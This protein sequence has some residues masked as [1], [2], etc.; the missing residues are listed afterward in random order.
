MN[1]QLVFGETNEPRNDLDQLNYGE[2]SFRLIKEGLEGE[3]LTNT[4][5]INTECLLKVQ[6]TASS[7]SDY[8]TVVSFDLNDD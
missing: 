8:E 2:M 7:Q 1:F 3:C 6:M 5:Q 4:K